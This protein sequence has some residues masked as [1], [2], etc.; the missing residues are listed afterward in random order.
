MGLVKVGFRS[1]M[2]CVGELFLVWQVE[3]I[4]HRQD[5]KGKYNN[6][7]TV[8]AQKYCKDNDVP[9]CSLFAPNEPRFTWTSV[10]TSV[11]WRDAV[12]SDVILS[13]CVTS[14]GNIFSSVPNS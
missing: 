2:L 13:S 12:I 7:R 3:I 14:G 8:N 1:V 9:E 10:F 11:I 5:S 6:P 4:L